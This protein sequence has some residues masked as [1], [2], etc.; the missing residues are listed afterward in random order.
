M[1]NRLPLIE[2]VHLLESKLGDRWTHPI[3]EPFKFDCFD[4]LKVQEAGKKIAQHLGL[5]PL[6][7]VIT[8]AHQKSKVGGHI[9]LDS[10]KDVFIEIDDKFKHDNDIVLAVLAHEICHKYLDINNLRD[11]REFENEM[12]TDASTI[13]TGLGKLSLNG[14]E[15]SDT[16]IGLSPNTK[17]T[18]TTQKVG[19]MNRNQFAFVYRLVC[20]MRRIPEESMMQGLTP[21]A[22]NEVKNVSNED[23]N[24]FNA[25]FFNNDFTL[26]KISDVMKNEVGD[27]Q[28]KFARLNKNM[29]VIQDRVLPS[30]DQL[31]KDFHSFTKTKT[32]AINSAASKSFD[33][34]SHNYIKNLVILE[35]Y[36]FF[37]SRII[38]KDKEIEKL[39]IT[40][41]EFV[42]FISVSFPKLYSPENAEFLFQFE[43][44]SCKNKM[45]VSERKLVRV[46]CPKCN[47][48]FVIDTGAEETVIAK[49]KTIV[50]KNQNKNGLWIKIKS[51]FNNHNK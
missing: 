39:G 10:S 26:H 33:K 27:S 29:R 13:Y 3:L 36:E 35:E 48:S 30:A 1:I 37:K 7:F 43:C 5:P 28:K 21:E 20:E 47:Y 42:N 44:P 49:S 22:I 41:S 15:K 31:Y 11:F 24:Y 25:I 2:K 6:T 38:E 12:L 34:E 14:C 16:L 51:L 46:K 4:T 18:T 23:S 32:E 45:R 40:L 8:Y 17:T 50:T 9:N 19:Y